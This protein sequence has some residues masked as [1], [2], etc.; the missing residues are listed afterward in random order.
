M[1][2][3]QRIKYALHSWCPGYTGWFRY[4]GA[5]VYFPPKAWIFKL[6]CEQG[7]YEAELLSLVRSL[8]RSN[9]WYFDVGANIGLMSVPIVSQRGDVKVMSFEPSPNTSPSIRRTVAEAGFGE[10]WRLCEKAAG[11]SPGEM[12]FSY[13]EAHLGGF[14]GLRHT[15]RA[16]AVG[17]QKVQV[18]TLDQE[19]TQLG[20]PDVSFVKLDIEGAELEALAGAEEMVRQCHPW[21]LLEWY[22]GN[23]PPY[24]VSREAI[25]DYGKSHGY[26]VLAVP[27]MTPISSPALLEVLMV[28]TSAFLLCP[29]RS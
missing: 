10:R 6:A 25:L 8:L 4:F 23:L 1:T 2:L 26:D 9:S 22:D 21:L 7:I 11:R 14:D 18:T 27:F 20:K 28:R 15:G 24:G 29:T 17:R 16:A 13:G 19:W 12:E 3:R 5:R